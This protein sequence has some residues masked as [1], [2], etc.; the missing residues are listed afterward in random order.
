MLSVARRHRTIKGDIMKIKHISVCCYG[1][2]IKHG[3]MPKES[4]GTTF[5][6][7][8][9]DVCGEHKGVTASRHYRLYEI[10]DGK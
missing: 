7:D 10:K 9:C 3:T 6:M 5:W 1:C 4:C 2:G 8:K